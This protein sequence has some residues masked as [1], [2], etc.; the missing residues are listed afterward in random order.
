M[1]KTKR[2]TA[3]KPAKEDKRPS[4]AKTETTVKD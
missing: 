4:T 3:T 1:Q 2:S